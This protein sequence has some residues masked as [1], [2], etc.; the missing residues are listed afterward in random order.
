M[1]MLLLLCWLVL[2]AD[3]VHHTQDNW[4]LKGTLARNKLTSTD[5]K[6]Y[7]VGYTAGWS[8]LAIVLP[9]IND[10]YHYPY[11]FQWP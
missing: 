5:L 3:E 8:V 10:S 11:L 2:P 6:I 7:G 1:C 9:S 4:G